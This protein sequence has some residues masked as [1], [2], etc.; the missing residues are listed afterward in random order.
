MKS[1]YE[2]YYTAKYNMKFA[3]EKAAY[4]A[5][6]KQ[7]LAAEKDNRWAKV[8]VKLAKILINAGTQLKIYAETKVTQSAYKTVQLH[9]L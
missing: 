9:E 8:L 2:Y 3:H 6:V 4:N 7:A 1:D 5:L